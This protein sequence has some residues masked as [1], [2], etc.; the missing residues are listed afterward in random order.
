MN[1]ENNIKDVISKKL[2][3]G[4]V[5]KLIAEQLESGVKNALKDLLG[6]YG[7]VTKVIEKQIKS[8]MIPYLEGYDY[9]EYIV[10][11]D[12]V[13]VEVLKSTASENKN[14]LDNFKDL[15]IPLDKKEINIS[16]VFEEWK[17]HVAKN[18][19]TDDLEICYDDG[20]PTYYDVTASMSVEEYERPRF[21]SSMLRGTVTF[22]CDEDEELGFELPV[23][24]W[25]DID[26]D[27]WRIDSGFL[28]SHNVQSLR[29]LSEFE[30]FLMRLK[31]AGTKIILDSDYSTDDEVEV[32]KR[33]EVE[34]S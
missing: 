16:E 34:W 13:M 22:T 12:H 15:M 10:K 1:L 20:E 7:E 21:S 29:K 19:E 28:E 30:I 9:S 27:K 17:K 4:I 8:V 26:K 5:E 24:S 31:Q 32:V 6:S 14:I 25:T 3:E 2:E 23:Y 33:P 11:L 18:V